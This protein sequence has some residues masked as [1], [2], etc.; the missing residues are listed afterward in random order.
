MEGHAGSIAPPSAKSEVASPPPLCRGKGRK[1]IVTNTVDA[2]LRRQPRDPSPGVYRALRWLLR[3]W[4]TL[5]FSRIRLLNVESLSNSGPALFVVNHP[6]SFFDALILIAAFDRPI[7]CLLDQREIRGGFAAWVASAL[8]VIPC[9]CE[10]EGWRAALGPGAAVLA[11]RGAVMGFA[12]RQSSSHRREGLRGPQFAEFAATLAM[13]AEL[14]QSGE[15]GLSI[16]PLHLFLPVAPSRSNEVLISIDSPLFAADYSSLGGTADN[17]ARALALALEEACRQN[18]FRLEPGELRT[19]LSDL[20]AVFRSELDQEWSSKSNWKQ[21]VE[22]FG[23]SRFLE[24]TLED[25]NVIHPG[26]II[27]LREAL[28]SCREGRRRFALRELELATA[29]DWAKSAAR[30]AGAWLETLIE[31]PIALYGLLNHLLVLAIFRGAGLLKVREEGS[32]W[33]ARAAVVLTCYAV[34]IGICGHYWGRAG[35]GYYALTLPFSG[36]LLWRFIWLLRHRSRLL[37]FATRASRLASRLARRQSRFLGDLNEARDDY[38]A[39]IGLPRA[40]F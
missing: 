29:G 6:G 33:A 34:Q 31:G 5:I 36:A 13:E 22:E 35:A 10:G 19:L 30:R 8:G 12:Y 11:D 2:P 25:L 38:A 32:V 3:A 15:L 16:F 20:E 18:V 26:R 1:R 28:E 24:R 39:L 14:R 37:Y 9:D 4:F 7:R 17:K 27:A 23:L 21:S 40:S